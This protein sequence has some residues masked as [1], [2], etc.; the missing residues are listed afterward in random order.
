MCSLSTSHL[1][2]GE[3]QSGEQKTVTLTFSNCGDQ[4]LIWSLPTLND[5]TL[6]PSTGTLEHGQSVTIQLTVTGNLK[7]GRCVQQRMIFKTNEYRGGEE[8][9]TLSYCVNE[10]LKVSHIQY[11]YIKQ[12]QAQVR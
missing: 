1:D 3:V 9:I 6:E 7:H 10:P 8:P 11:R 4:S 5:V 2:F 12:Q